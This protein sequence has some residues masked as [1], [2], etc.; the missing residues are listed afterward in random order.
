MISH[1]DEVHGWTNWVTWSVFSWFSNDESAY[2]RVQEL[3]QE[4]ANAADLACKLQELTKRECS[5][6][7][8]SSLNEELLSGA[9][10]TVNWAEIARAVRGNTSVDAG[11]VHDRSNSQRTVSCPADAAAIMRSTIAEATMGD[12]EEFWVVLLD[13]R[14]RE[15]CSQMVYRGTVT[16]LRVR[17]AEVFKEA[18]RQNAPSIVVAHTHPSGNPNPSDA[19]I[20]VTVAMVEAGLLLDVVVVDHLIICQDDWVSLRE[21]GI[22]FG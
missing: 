7:E 11:E 17:V 2:A 21:R 10:A 5:V 3:D 13:A 15:L 22:G 16:G 9:L 1:T 14:H 12:Q 20:A 4:C 18:I 8:R 19:D 6:E